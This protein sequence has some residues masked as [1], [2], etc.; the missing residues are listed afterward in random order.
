MDIL[1]IDIDNIINVQCTRSSH[2]THRTHSIIAND[3]I[4]AIK[5]L[6]HDQKDGASEV[7]SEHLIYS[8][9]LDTRSQVEWYHCSHP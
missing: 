1:K 5:Q 9:I 2:C 4:A 8:C 3:V 7:V 6:K